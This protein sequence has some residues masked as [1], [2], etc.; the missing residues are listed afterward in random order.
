MRVSGA[1][2]LVR[3]LANSGVR[4][5]FANPGTTEVSLLDALEAETRIRPILGLHENVIT[6]AADGFGRIGRMPAITVMH[7]GPGLSNGCAN[8]HNAK[9]AQTPIINIIGNHPADLLKLDPP[10]NMD[11]VSLAKAFSDH[12]EI[13]TEVSTMLSCAENAL[14]LS[15]KGKVVS[16][17]VSADAFWDMIEMDLDEKEHI[18]SIHLDL[19]IKSNV[20][21]TAETIEQALKNSENIAFLLGAEALSSEMNLLAIEKIRYLLLSKFSTANIKLVHESFPARMEVGLGLPKIERAPYSIESASTYFESIKHLILIGA[22]IPVAYFANKGFSNFIIPSTVMVS[23]LVTTN[24]DISV[25]IKQLANHFKAS[26]IDVPMISL[27]RMMP[28]GKL[29]PK[30]VMAAVSWT[31]PPCSIVIDEA[32]SSSGIFLEKANNSNRCSYLSLTGGACGMALSAAIGASLAA[33]EQKV[34]TLVGDGSATYSCQALWTQAKNRLN[35]VNII[36]N[37]NSYRI[38]QSEFKNRTGSEL[39]KC[40]KLLTEID[41]PRIDWVLLARSYG[42]QNAK[43]VSSVEM[44]IQ[45]L[46]D[47]FASAGP[48]LISVDLSGP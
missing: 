14:K 22:K 12:V 38:L 35:I 1:T 19:E 47:S 33:P 6:G 48:T 42:F 27:P 2:A 15:R 25:A 5:C 8:L 16:M 11:V 21:K 26:D 4:Y 3:F 30:S 32:I 10:M 9:R 20:E 29:N 7:L 28:Q 41:N 34:I 43:S 40:G 46:I 44:L 36:L 24:Q 37:N 39:G 45:T 31:M 17:I 13:V 18:Q 23:D